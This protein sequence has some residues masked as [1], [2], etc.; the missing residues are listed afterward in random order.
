[1]TVVDN[2]GVKN[3]KSVILSTVKS[4]VKEPNGLRTCWQKFAI[5]ISKNITMG[6][7]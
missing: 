4:H 6:G 7:G 5:L 3:R 2:Y 1:M